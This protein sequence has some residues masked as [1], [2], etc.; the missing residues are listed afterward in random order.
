MKSGKFVPLTEYREYPPDEMKARA[1]A[2]Y[3]DLKRRRSVRE[4]SPRPVD[5]EIIEQCLLAAGTAPNGANMQPWQFVVVSDPEIKKK[6]RS[7]AEEVEADFYNRRAPQY[8]L[9]ALAPLGTDEHKE[10]LE[11]APYL[12]VIFAKRHTVLP[13]GSRKKHYYISESVGIATGMLITALHTAGLACLTHT[14]SP[15][16]F[17]RDVLERPKE[18]DAFLL[19]V[20]GHPK[21]GC[22][23]PEITKKSL[24][25]IAV[26]R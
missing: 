10:F 13:D 3:H 19:L 23:V 11:I 25:E 26:F 20:V 6:I 12:I 5:R 8:W 22:A 17:L 16:A 18:E 15:M 21:D 7:A 9:D 1:E 2:F 4:F 24:E 14:P